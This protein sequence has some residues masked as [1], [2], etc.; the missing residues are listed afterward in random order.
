M[1][2]G[3]LFETGAGGSAPKH[4]QQ[5]VK[6]NY[7]RWD[8]LGE[9]LALAASLRAPRRDHR[10]P[11]RPG[12][13]R[14]PRPGH[15]HV[16]RTRTSRP[17]AR[18]ASIDNRGSHFYLALYWAQELAAAD[19][20]P[21]ARRGVR[22]PRRDARRQRADD[23]RRADRRPGLAGRHRRL[24]PPRRRQGVGGD[25][26]VGRRS[27][28][29][30]PRLAETA[31]DL[32]SVRR[33]PTTTPEAGP[34][35]RFGP[36]LLALA[37]GGFA[38]GT[39]EFM[40]MGLLPQVADGVGVSIPTAGHLISAYALGVV[41]GAPVLAFSRRPAAAA[42]PAGRPD[43][44]RTPPRT[45]LSARRRLLRAAVSLPLPVRRPARRLFGVASLVAAEPGPARPRGPR[46]RHGDDRAVG[47]QRRRRPRRDLAR[48]SLGW[49]SAFWV[50][51]ALAVLTAALVVAFLPAPAP[52]TPKP[53][54]A[55]AAACS[56]S[57]R[58]G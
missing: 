7:L 41:V 42:R 34:T 26:P 23:R 37:M 38:I 24:L 20:R 5:L 31:P 12:P 44:R 39:T 11:A 43:G 32:A 3:G 53:P 45:S 17:R 30:S 46:R 51:P 57:R 13:R 8:S 16:P 10:Q 56:R 40:A 28:T 2:G 18:S 47:R 49:R 25:A 22:R 36:A 29:R 6:E 52:A 1:N 33:R 50:A 54:A 14:H 19:R 4:V 55:R 58:S 15:R 35:T 9:F 21:R 27:T 48:H